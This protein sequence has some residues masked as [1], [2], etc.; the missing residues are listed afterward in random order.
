MPTLKEVA[1]LAKV[2]VTTASRVLNDTGPA[3]GF[4][5]ACAAR[6]KD[7]AK[8]L[9]YVRNY[10]AG[11]LRAG[12]ALAVGF[13][14]EFGARAQA[15][16]DPRQSMLGNDYW[17]RVIGGVAFAARQSGYQLNLIGPTHAEC[18]LELAFRHLRERRIDGLVVPAQVRQEL[19][20]P[21]LE[22]ADSPVIVVGHRE[23]TLVPVV[24]YDEPAAVDALVTH[25][26]ELGHRSVLWFGPEP[27]EGMESHLRRPDLFARSAFHAGIAG[28]IERFGRDVDYPHPDLTIDY[29]YQAARDLL[30]GPRDFTAVVCY[31]DHVAIGLCRA[32]HEAGLDLPADLSVVGFDNFVAAHA[33]PPLTTVSHQCETMGQRTFELLEKMIA[34][35][36]TR[37]DLCGHCETV[38]PRLVVRQSTAPP[39]CP[40]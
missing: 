32:A 37:R 28:R 3:N 23:P 15:V 20:R 12:K 9:G 34:D 26:A 11:S 36:Q 18:G 8:Q 7:A 38:T 22:S 19:W 1:Q 6:V 27:E 2:S 25:L 35:G 5:A 29:A 31:N 21:L 4:S 14:F 17:S 16:D 24:D 30:Q 10:H 40:R 39:R 33:W 13:A